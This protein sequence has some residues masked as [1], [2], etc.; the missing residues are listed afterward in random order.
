MLPKP[1]TSKRPFLGEG[2]KCSGRKPVLDS[3]GPA[4][5]ALCDS[6]RSLRCASLHQP[7][8]NSLF[9]SQRILKQKLFS[10]QLASSPGRQFLR[11]PSSE[12]K[13]AMTWRSICIPNMQRLVSCK[14]TIATTC[15][16]SGTPRDCFNFSALVL[17][18]IMSVY[19]Y[20]WTEAESRA[21][22]TGHPMKT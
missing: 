4:S 15:Q 18:V 13:V 2:A 6:G 1:C 21:T 9:L 16:S 10:H 12:G 20:P 22:R 8:F 17:S 7:T 5:A 11:S 3:L 14:Y 19:R